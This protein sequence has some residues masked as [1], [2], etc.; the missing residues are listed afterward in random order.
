VRKAA[1]PGR[2]LHSSKSSIEVIQVKQFL[3]MKMVQG[4]NQMAGMIALPGLYT[5][6]AAQQFVNNA[7]AHEPNSMYVIQEV[8]AA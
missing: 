5:L 7:M 8:G 4:L 2:L 1:L 6:E 3:V